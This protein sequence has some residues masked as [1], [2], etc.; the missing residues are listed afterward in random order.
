[1]NIHAVKERLQ[2]NDNLIQS[3]SF[4][5]EQLNLR[6]ERGDF[7]IYEAGRQEVVLRNQTACSMFCTKKEACDAK[8]CDQYLRSIQR[9]VSFIDNRFKVGITKC[10]NLND[11]FCEVKVTFSP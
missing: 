5:M 2:E 6:N 11:A 7:S 4:V 8:F 1:M 9:G 10:A 3:S